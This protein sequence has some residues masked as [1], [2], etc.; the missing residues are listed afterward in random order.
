MNVCKLFIIIVCSKRLR[1]EALLLSALR[2][3]MYVFPLYVSRVYPNLC[4]IQSSSVKYFAEETQRVMC[5]F[6][7]YPGR[8]TEYNLCNFSYVYGIS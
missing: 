1:F 2:K 7:T 8:I 5:S 3:R 4:Q 6:R